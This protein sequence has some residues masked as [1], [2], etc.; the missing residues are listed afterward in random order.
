MKNIV[1]TINLLLIVQICLVAQNQP[2]SPTLKE[3]PANVVKKPKRMLKPLDTLYIEVKNQST[4]YLVHKVK[5]KQTLYSIAK[6]YNVSQ[7]DLQFSNPA[8][9]KTGLSVGFMLK[10]PIAL[11]VVKRYKSKKFI[12]WRS[13][14]VFYKI[15]AKETIYRLAKFHFRMPSGGFMAKPKSINF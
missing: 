1:L 2:K 8:L 15:K 5:P 14:P 11:P 3:A 4:R 10:I 12:K 13:I 6:Y 7:S 9:A